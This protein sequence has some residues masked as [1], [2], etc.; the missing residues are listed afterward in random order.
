MNREDV[1]ARLAAALASLDFMVSIDIYLNETSRHAT[2][3]PSGAS[4]WTDE[5]SDL[6]VG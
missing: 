6:Q 5:T 1:L 2:F 3:P 4:I